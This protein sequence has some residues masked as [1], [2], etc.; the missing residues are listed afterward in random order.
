MN[1]NILFDK[2]LSLS[3]S[4]LLRMKNVSVNVA[5]KMETHILCSIRSAPPP[6]PFM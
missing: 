3:L 4:I 2:S 5:D 1:N 6:K